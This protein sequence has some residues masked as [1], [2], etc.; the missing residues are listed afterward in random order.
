MDPCPQVLTEHGAGLKFTFLPTSLKRLPASPILRSLIQN[1]P[2]ALPNISL[3]T[4]PPKSEAALF[5]PKQL[6]F[7]GWRQQNSSS[8]LSSS[9]DKADWLRPHPRSLLHRGRHDMHSSV[10]PAFH[11]HSTDPGTRLDLQAGSRGSIF[12]DSSYSV[13]SSMMRA[14]SSKY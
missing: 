7:P 13:S 14:L 12:S 5:D 8:V 6:A 9:V 11:E 3:S 10:H 1:V 2:S 4:F